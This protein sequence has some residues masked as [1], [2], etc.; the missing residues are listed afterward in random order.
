MDIGSGQLLV[1]VNSAEGAAA[2]YTQGLTARLTY[3]SHFVEA[4]P[5]EYDRRAYVTG[6][7]YLC[8]RSIWKQIRQDPA[9]EWNKLEDVEFGQRAL[10]QYGV[11]PRVNPYAFAFTSRTRAVLL[12]SHEIL[13]RRGDG[14]VVSYSSTYRSGPKSTADTGLPISTL[15]ARAWDIYTEFGFPEHDLEMRQFIFC[16]P[17]NTTRQFA[18]FW[19]RILYNLVVPR[20]LSAIQKLLMKFS[21]AAFGFCY[22]A[23]TLSTLSRSIKE[24]AFFVDAIIRDNYFNRTLA[25]VPNLINADDEKDSNILFQ[26]TMNLWRQGG[27][28]IHFYESFDDLWSTINASLG[29]NTK[30]ESPNRL[31][32][33]P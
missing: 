7:L 31:P 17:I 19:I 11:P 32:N 16:T 2:L 3:R 23:G 13:S 20:Q 18:A 10:S 28:Y 33:L 22:D 26:Q 24:G 12:G 9:I 21:T 29:P 8:K 4:H 27:D 1:D 5:D 14:H 25:N 15:R 6:S 30:T